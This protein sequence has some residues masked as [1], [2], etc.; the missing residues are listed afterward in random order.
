[1]NILQMHQ[2]A[3][4]KVNI[5]YHR[6]L[7]RYKKNEKRIYVFCEGNED[8]G[9]YVQAISKANPDLMLLP[10]LAEYFGVSI[11]NLFYINGEENILEENSANILEHNSSWW[12]G[13]KEADMTTIALPDYGFYTPTEDTLCLMGDVRGKN[14]LEV[15]CG[16][17][18]IL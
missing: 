16:R 3:T 9:Y 11:D 10:K 2:R 12:A 4:K 8:F 7:N 6:F 15:A 5:Y 18:V 1:M 17:G 13:I 14:V